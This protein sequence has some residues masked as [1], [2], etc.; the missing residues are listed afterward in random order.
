M[1]TLSFAETIMVGL[2]QEW[3]KGCEL[4]SLRL[5]R[6]VQDLLGRGEGRG[7]GRWSGQ[8]Q[9]GHLVQNQATFFDR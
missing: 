1:V 4:N 2:E 7:G 6:I 9:R 5:Y 8:V 3:A